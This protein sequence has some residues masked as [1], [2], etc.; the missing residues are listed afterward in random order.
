MTAILADKFIVFSFLLMPMTNIILAMLFHSNSFS[1]DI[2]CF[3][4]FNVL[5]IVTREEVLFRL[6]LQNW[7]ISILSNKRYYAII[8]I[9]FIF[10]VFHFLNINGYTNF[11]YIILQSICAFC[12]GV[13]LSLIYLITKTIMPCIIMHGLINISSLY[14]DSNIHNSFP[15]LMLF[16]I[17]VYLVMCVS[18]LWL[19]HKL[20]RLIGD[21]DN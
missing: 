15:D 7:F 18:Y 4:I 16:D 9:N 1:T 6:I 2:S 20:L 5:V 12:V 8:A 3:T 17:Y 14:I 13:N 10:S 21:D 11:T 19:N